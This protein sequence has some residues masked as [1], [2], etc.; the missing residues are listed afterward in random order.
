MSTTDTSTHV[1]EEHLQIIPEESR[2]TNVSGQFWIWAAVNLAPVNWILGGLG[3]QLG[4]GLWET[5]AVLAIGNVLAASVFGVFV[6]IGQKTGV[7]ALVL[8]RASFGRLGG[9]V[10]TLFQCLGTLGWA[11]VNTWVV[12]DLI[13]ALL[14]Q[15]GIVGAEQDGVFLRSC[16]AVVIMAL[17]LAIAL[18]GFKI[19]SRFERWTTPPTLVILLFMTIAAW[20]FL[21]PN[22]GYAGDAALSGAERFSAITTVMTAIGIGWG[23]TFFTYAADYSRFVKTS[24]PRRRLYLTAVSG[25]IIPVLWLGLLGAS[26]AAKFPGDDPGEL[27][28]ENFG[29]LAIPV[30][31]LV[32]HGPLAKNSFNIY[33]FSLT[34][35]AL[36]I[37]IGRKKISVAAALLALALAFLLIVFSEYGSAITSWLSALAVWICAW[38]GVVLPHYFLVAKRRIVAANLFRTGDGAGVPAFDWRGIVAFGGGIVGGWLF[39]FG[40]LPLFQGPIARALA[41]AD[42]SWLAAFVVSAGLYLLIGAFARRAPRRQGASVP[43]VP[44]MEHEA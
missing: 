2:T 12:L 8:S 16:I 35:Q 37:R 39:M 22:W 23:V 33:S 27:I 19:I 15:S 10:P 36:D 40:G 14:V 13:V 21:E 32:I 41:G 6:L 44:A 30:L 43:R 28:V 3:I 9:Y 18:G 17:Q 1:H 4:L 31:L 20:G 42:L 11:A 7:T 38:A 34:V 24:V 29:V 25:Q 26:L 5:F